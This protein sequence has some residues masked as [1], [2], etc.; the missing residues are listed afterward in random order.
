MW[1]R[2]MKI[3][4]LYGCHQISNR[5]FFIAQYQFPVCARCTG[6]LVGSIIAYTLIFFYTP[7]LLFCKF[8]CSIMF[9]D[10]LFQYLSIKDSTN[11]RRLITGLIG[12]YS[13]SSIICIAVIFIVN[14]IKM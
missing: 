10:W 11:V 3:G 6:A 9:I 8:G 2:L 1:I 5:S 13:F 14:S 7:P 12:G 4:T